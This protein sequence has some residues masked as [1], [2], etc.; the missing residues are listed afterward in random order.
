M[1][2]YIN[3][4]HNIYN[5]IS[6]IVPGIQYLL[7]GVGLGYIHKPGRP[8]W[9]F[10]QKTK[11]FALRQQSVSIAQIS[12]HGI[13][14]MIVDSKRSQQKSKEAMDYTLLRYIYVLHHTRFWGRTAWNYLR[15]WGGGVVHKDD[16]RVQ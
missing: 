12:A 14:D 2:L 8:R 15:A 5:V 13:V 16:K 9:K 7:K 6:Y 4:Q 10:T 3:H 1:D 11:E